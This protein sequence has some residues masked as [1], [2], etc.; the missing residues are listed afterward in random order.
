MAVGSGAERRPDERRD[1]QLARVLSFEFAVRYSLF[2]FD[3]RYH[4][5]LLAFR[6]SLFASANA[7]L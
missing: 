3:F 4:I 6:F 1:Q 5:S 7:C 2:I